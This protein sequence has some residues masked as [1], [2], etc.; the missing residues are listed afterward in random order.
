MEE[1]LLKR[2]EVPTEQTW[3]L[4]L[5]YKSEE[6]LQAD[7]KKAREL[8]KQI[9]RFKGKLVTAEKINA[10]L[11]LLEQ[12]YILQDHLG[13]YYSLAME[14]DHTD[15]RLTEQYNL[16]E[17]EF[18]AMNASIQFVDDEIA[19][20]TIDKETLEKYT[21]RLEEL[22]KA[23]EHIGLTNVIRTMQLTYHRADL[24]KFSNA[25]DHGAHVELY[26]PMELSEEAGTETGEHDQRKEENHDHTDL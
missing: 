20:G 21:S 16:L 13:N 9:R 18:T 1:R 4:T 17:N 7:R 26:I 5:L 8:A 19:R 6:E 14:V 10:C 22:P 15:S 11:T 12:L 24:V 2:K 23:K 25:P 3:D